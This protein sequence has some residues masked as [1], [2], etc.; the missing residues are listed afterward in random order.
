MPD[1]E[2]QM[3]PLEPPPEPPS[4][5]PPVL[6]TAR[7]AQAGP[8]LLQMF[9]GFVSFWCLLVGIVGLV[10]LVSLMKQHPPYAGAWWILSLVQLGLGASLL[11]WRARQGRGLVTGLLIGAGL[12]GLIGLGAGLCFAVLK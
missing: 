4:P 1:Q 2:P 6:T 12:L 7:P 10:I 5:L 8:Y 3:P 9:L 11:G